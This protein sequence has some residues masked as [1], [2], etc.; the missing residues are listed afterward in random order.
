MSRLDDADLR[1][2]AAA[3]RRAAGHAIV[4]MP[5]EQVDAAVRL[6]AALYAAALE[7]GL[8]PADADGVTSFVHASIDGVCVVERRRSTGRWPA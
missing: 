2:I 1:R 4:P 7:H 3:V 8:E 5:P 6:A